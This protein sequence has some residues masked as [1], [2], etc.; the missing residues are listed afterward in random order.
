MSH[1]KTIV[2]CALNGV[3]T[4][5]ETHPVPVTP[6]Q[7]A[8]AA[9]EAYDAGASIVHCHFRRQEPGKGAL[10]SWDPE[11][12]AACCEAIKARV[13]EIIINMSTGSPGADISGQVACLERVKPEMAAMN[14]GSLNYLKTRADGSWA[15]KPMLFDNP[16]E[17]IAAFL[18]VMDDN[19]IVPECECF[20]TGIVRS[21]SMF[22]ANG[23]LKAPLHASLVMGVASGMPAK[24]AW[25]PLLLEELPP[26]AHWQVI[27]I[28]RQEIWELHRKCA[29]LGGHV[30]TG[31]EDTFYLPNGEK[32]QS[33]G[34]LIEALVQM[35]EATGRQV[36][37]PA[38]TREML[39]ITRS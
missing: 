25:L 10:P 27:A 9:A 16:V 28:G 19:G 22:L 1:S 26:Q 20:D 37:T 32:T 36:A 3:L 13:P 33:N 15:W 2:T 8:A 30:R 12:V 34:V 18:K 6:E 38:E 29:E 11:V 31:L 24:A 17:K 35:V 14:A 7:M 5:P 23:L 39:G 4:N 21:L